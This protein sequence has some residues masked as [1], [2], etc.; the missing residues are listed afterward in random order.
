MAN[1]RILVVDDIY[2]NRYLLAQLV[3]LTGNEVVQAENGE[4]AIRILEN[5]KIDLVF[6]DIEMPVMNGLEA[7][8]YIREKLP[9]PKCNT[10]IVALTAHNPKIFFDDYKD[11]GFNQ[12]LTKPYSVKKIT[13]LFEA[14]TSKLRPQNQ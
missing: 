2:T 14:F 5:E 12:L 11:V 3:K 8:M 7:T 1:L 4:E 9:P 13:E 6:M 10:T